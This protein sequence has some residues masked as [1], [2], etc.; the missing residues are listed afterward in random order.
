MPS[1]SLFAFLWVVTARAQSNLHR[2]FISCGLCQSMPIA[3]RT[4]LLM[5]QY[6][7][8]KPIPRHDSRVL[9]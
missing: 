3:A 8:Q 2:G 7:N 5:L 4:S 9:L 1:A 6:L